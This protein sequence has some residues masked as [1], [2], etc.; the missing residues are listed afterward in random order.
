MWERELGTILTRSEDRMLDRDLQSATVHQ[1]CHYKKTSTAPGKPE[2]RILL[3]L[4]R[5]LAGR[6]IQIITVSSCLFFKRCFIY[7]MLG[8]VWKSLEGPW[9][10][11]CSQ[12]LPETFEVKP[13]PRRRHVQLPLRAWNQPLP[14]VDQQTWVSSDSP[15]RAMTRG[16]SSSWTGVGS[17]KG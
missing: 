8:T 12:W 5:L 7:K 9:G 11:A 2:E 4:Q 1:A 10:R 17:W 13:R 16:A 3:S 14:A 6:A 15:G